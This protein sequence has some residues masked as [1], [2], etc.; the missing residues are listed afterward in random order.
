MRL[1]YTH[2]NY[3][4]QGSGVCFPCM[5]DVVPV[6]N[7]D[8]VVIMF[9]LNFEVMTDDT[10]HNPALQLN[11]RLPLS[12]RPINRSWR[13]RL[14]LPLLQSHSAS[15]SSLQEDPETGRVVALRGTAPL[16]ASSSHESLA[17]TE[18]LSL[19]EH[20][21]ARPG[22]ATTATAATETPSSSLWLEDR[23]TLLGSDLTSSSP[24]PPPA[25][26]LPLGQS[27]P[28]PPRL[29]TEAS[30][31][32]CSLTPSRSRESFHSMRR[33]SSVDD[34]E[35]MRPEW[36][37]KHGPRVSSSS[38]D[39]MRYRTIS[40][41]PQ[42]TLNFVDFKPDPLIALPPGE[43]DIIAPCK[44]MD[45]THNVTE[46]VTQILKEIWNGKTPELLFHHFDGSNNGPA[47][48][49]AGHVGMFIDSPYIRLRDI[50]ETRSARVWVD[51]R[52]TSLRH[53][54]LAGSGAGGAPAEVHQPVAGGDGRGRWRRQPDAALRIMVVSLA[55]KLVTE[56][57]QCPAPMQLCEAGSTSCQGW[58]NSNAA[59]LT[60]ERREV[61]G[62]SLCRADKEYACLGEMT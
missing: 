16:P 23:R 45:R 28:R 11:H 51:A 36:E 58:D 3:T 49:A 4:Q 59:H 18:L 8:G 19:R 30:V 21:Q 29:N 43:I 5:V 17:L 42:I 41:I 22:T 56:L 48:L 10:P 14:R 37:R 1:I 47:V 12:W 7:E 53:V 27:S 52:W 15:Q 9:I 44:L 46:K 33:A 25:P 24:G 32:N 62:D 26:A 57:L 34:I 54:R 6:K 61:S 40:K 20:E 38:T 35:A 13:L 55:L 2:D 31:S 60:S 50:R 39:L